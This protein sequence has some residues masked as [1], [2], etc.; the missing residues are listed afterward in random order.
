M[1]RIKYLFLLLAVMIVLPFTVHAEGEETTTTDAND[2]R[3]IVYFFRGEGCSHCAEA[4]EWFDSIQETYGDKFVIKDY[5]TW[6]DEDNAEL[7]TKVAEARG[8]EDRAT[9]VPYIIIA[10]HSWFGFDGETYPDEILSKIDEVYAQDVSERYDMEAIINGTDK[11]EDS[12]G[13]DVVALLIILVVVA[14]GCFGIYKA[15]KTTD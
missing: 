7:M 13:K 6:Y 3:V 1:K 11:K 12:T 2:N 14:A 8:E 15:R 10:D 5:E 4:I 9:G